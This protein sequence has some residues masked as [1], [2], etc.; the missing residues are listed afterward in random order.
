MILM[1]SENSPLGFPLTPTMMSPGWM[2]GLQREAG[3]TTPAGISFSFWMHGRP[4]GDFTRSNPMPF[5]PFTT[6]VVT[7]LGPLG[8]ERE[9]GTTATAGLGTGID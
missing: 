1:V 2:G 4:L 6:E 7:I 9:G 8:A 5:S 3:F